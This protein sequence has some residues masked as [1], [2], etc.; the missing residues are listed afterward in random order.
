MDRDDRPAVRLSCDCS[1]DSIRRGMAAQIGLPVL[2]A[3]LGGGLMKVA[4]LIWK[5]R[6]ARYGVS[7][8]PAHDPGAFRGRKEASRVVWVGNPGSFADWP[9]DVLGGAGSGATSRSNARHGRGQGADLAGGGT[10]R[11]SVMTM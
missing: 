9:A 11:Q 2:T 10:S 6:G 5:F 8:Y 4:D 3:I 1:S 7:H